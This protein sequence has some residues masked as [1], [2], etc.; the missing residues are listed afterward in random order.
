MKAFF[1]KT[2]PYYL[3]REPTY[4]GHPVEVSQQVLNM[5]DSRKATLVLVEEVL[6]E[7]ALD[8][9]AQTV[10][11]MFVDLLEKEISLLYVEDQ[12]DGKE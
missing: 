6:D 4:D 8:D 7:V 10:T 2:E 5:L 12:D 9:E 1:D 3:S 11:D